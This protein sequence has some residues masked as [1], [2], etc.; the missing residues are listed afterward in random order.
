MIVQKFRSNLILTVVLG[1]FTLLVQAQNLVPNGGFE[2]G[3]TCPSMPGNVTEECAFWYSSLSPINSSSPE[4]FH[5][6]SEVDALTPPTVTGGVQE[7]YEGEGYC[8]IFNVID[9]PTSPDYREII[10]VE[11]LNSLELGH[12]YLVKF[13]YSTIAHTPDIAIL[14]NKLG[15]NFSTHPTYNDDAFP[16]N[17]SHYSVDT[18]ILLTDD[19]LTISQEFVADSA[20]AYFHIGIFH[21]DNEI[22]NLFISEN[23]FRAAYVI[24]DVSI[25]EVLLSSG[26]DRF[27]LNLSVY[28]NPFLNFLNVT[29][30]NDFSI[31][32]D[33]LSIISM[34]GDLLEVK[35]NEIAGK[36]LQ[37][38][39]S[40]L[41]SGVY[42]IHLQSQNKNY[43]E[44]IV[45]T[46]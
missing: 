45:K 44:K 40:H 20:Y 18:L 3:I 25:S 24:D 8:G 6:C 5:T 39:L 35:L 7:P 46:N 30:P 19:W 34:Q 43:Y 14:T 27:M 17:T 31:R 37:L 38:D 10:G 42:I 33:R 28:P 15:F 41:S 4:W 11:L 2:E 9:N 1:I 26:P 16:I 12:T 21:D 29:L 36:N 32:T 23:S 22:E 13:R